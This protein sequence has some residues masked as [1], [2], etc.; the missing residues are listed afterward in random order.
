[1]K[2]N[3][4]SIEDKIFMFRYR[5]QWYVSYEQS[6]WHMLLHFINL[7]VDNI[8]TFGQHKDLKIFYVHL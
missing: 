3:E 7:H 5:M 8:L 2:K 1:M 4:D 6:L